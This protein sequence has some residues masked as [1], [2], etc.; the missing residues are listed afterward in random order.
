[1]GDGTRG[2]YV[3]LDHRETIEVVST[4]GFE[5]EENWMVIGVLPDGSAS[6]DLVI[7]GGF[8]S[9]EAADKFIKLLLSDKLA[10]TE[11]KTD[12]AQA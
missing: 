10:D 5:G 12:V 2:I 4:P 9:G 8:T 7:G 6:D 3:N 1:M 11:G